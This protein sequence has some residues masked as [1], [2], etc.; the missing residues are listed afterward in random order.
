MS[1]IINQKK[2]MI[3]A[4]S[5]TYNG[6]SRFLYFK[7]H[8]GK[9]YMKQTF[10]SDFNKELI[11]G[12]NPEEVKD[13]LEQLTRERTIFVT[14][15][16]FDMTPDDISSIFS[17]YGTVLEVRMGNMLSDQDKKLLFMGL[18]AFNEI[19]KDPIA[20]C[21]T[22]HV[23]FE[24]EKSVTKA[25]KQPIQNIEYIPSE[26]PQGLDRF[27]KLHKSQVLIPKKDKLKIDK[28]MESYDRM[29]AK[30]EVMIEAL[31]GQPDQDGFIKVVP[32]KGQKRQLPQTAE[33][34]KA[35]KKKKKNKGSVEISLYRFQNMEK[36]KEKLETLRDQFQK[37]KEKIAKMKGDRKFKP[38]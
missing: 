24:N 37:D 29:V 18:T 33:G 36:K 30:E 8:A 7:K 34:I 19:K 5:I 13:E 27:V 20:S 26:K 10:S 16:G 22:A 25:L 14:N 1:T 35:N 17:K 23:L 4:Q 12:N 9:L 11:Q 3:I 21:G 28:W 15:I 38:Q 6:V 32:K 31:E 2:T